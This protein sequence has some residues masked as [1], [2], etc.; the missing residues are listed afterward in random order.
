MKVMK[1]VLKNLE[2]DIKCKDVSDSRY[3][4]KELLYFLNELSVVYRH[5]SEYMRMQGAV[6][7]QASFLKKSTELY[8][9]CEENGIYDLED[10]E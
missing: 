7:S 1:I 5:A 8:K 10:V 3:S 9:I 2:I 6:N 4:K